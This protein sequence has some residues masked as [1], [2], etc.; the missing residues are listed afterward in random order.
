M[1]T[2][3]SSVRSWVIVM[4]SLMPR[5]YRNAYFLAKIRTNCEIEHMPLHLTCSWDPRSPY[6]HTARGS[7]DQPWP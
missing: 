6:D 4:C 5:A 7:G 2:G 1:M 3:I